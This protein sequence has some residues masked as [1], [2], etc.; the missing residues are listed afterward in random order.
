MLTVGVSLVT[1][2]LSFLAG[3]GFVPGNQSKSELGVTVSART[4]E[5]LDQDGRVAARIGSNSHGGTFELLRPGENGEAS[6]RFAFIGCQF[7]GGAEVVLSAP[8]GD[9]KSKLWFSVNGEPKTASIVG[10]SSNGKQ[11]FELKC[12]AD[13]QP[14]LTI[15]NVDG[16]G[17]R[18][19][20]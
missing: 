9:S 11:Q 15:W 17:V 3:A 4:F 19:E 12:A 8:E 6:R 13:E 7:K 16:G 10:T 5:V 2:S 20:K 18:F 1:A 14:A